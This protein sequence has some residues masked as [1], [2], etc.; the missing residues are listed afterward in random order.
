MF[1]SFPAE[2]P[3]VHWTGLRPMT[4][5]GRPLLGQTKIGN[6]IVNSGHGTLGWTMACGSARIVR[7]L[8][9]GRPAPLPLDAFSPLREA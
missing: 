9:A 7:E 5:D 1:P 6:L 2:R 3:A 4:P 8:V